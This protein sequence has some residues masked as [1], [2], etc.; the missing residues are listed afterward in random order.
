MMS[1]FS[2]KIC[3]YYVKLPAE[4]VSNALALTHINKSS[5]LLKSYLPVCFLMY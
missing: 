1:S 5:Q 4:F 2:D 3:H